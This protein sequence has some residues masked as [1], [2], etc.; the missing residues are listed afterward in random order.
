MRVEILLLIIGA[1]LSAISQLLLKTSADRYG[2]GRVFR[3]QYLNPLVIG[4]YGLLFIAMIIPLYALKHVDMKY[5]AIFE[6]LGYVFVMI[7]SAVFLRE[8][9]TRRIVI[10]NVFIVAGV[11]IFGLRLF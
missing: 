3:R 8:K 10:G 9:I 5:A 11:I 4:G 6:S 2:S 1:G 7:L